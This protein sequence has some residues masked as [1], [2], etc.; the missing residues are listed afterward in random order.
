[1][2]SKAKQKHLEE[3]MKFKGLQKA[4]TKQ[5]WAELLQEG[6]EWEVL[7]EQLQL[8]ATG[9]SELA[10]LVLASSRQSAVEFELVDLRLRRIE[11]A[12]NIETP[13][14]NE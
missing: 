2:D 1:M 10:G 11:K 5:R 4:V 7:Q 8:G 12:L 14:L 6:K 3:V 9:V 13:P